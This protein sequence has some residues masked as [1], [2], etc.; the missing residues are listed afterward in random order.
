[1][2]FVVGSVPRTAEIV[3]RIDDVLAED[4]LPNAIDY[5]LRKIRATRLR[6]RG[7]QFI[8]GNAAPEEVS[9]PLRQGMVGKPV[10]PPRTG[11]EE[12]TN[13]MAVLGVVQAAGRIGAFKREAERNLAMLGSRVATYSVRTV[14]EKVPN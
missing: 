3:R 13:R 11:L 6:K 1:L 12:V 7:G 9:H 2:S 14:L 5:E 10:I 8:I 4:L